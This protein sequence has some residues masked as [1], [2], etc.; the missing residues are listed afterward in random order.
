MIQQVRRAARLRCRIGQGADR[1]FQFEGSARA[2]HAGAN[3]R[4]L[5]RPGEGAIGMTAQPGG[6]GLQVDL[7]S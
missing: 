1:R 4:R 6:Q 7:R 5:E 2:G 3:R